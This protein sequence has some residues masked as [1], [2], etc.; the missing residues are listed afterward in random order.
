LL[1]TLAPEGEILCLRRRLSRNELERSGCWPIKDGEV[2]LAFAFERDGWKREEHPER[3]LRDSVLQNAVRGRAMFLRRRENG[4]N[5]AA[6]FDPVHSFPLVPL[7]CFAKIGRV[8]GKNCVLFYFD[9]DG[10]PTVPHNGSDTGENSG[11]S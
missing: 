3:L 7:F 1:G 10:N 11:I 6:I 4:F 5:L 8:E 9:R 2:V